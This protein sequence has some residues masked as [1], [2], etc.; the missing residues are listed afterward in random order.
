MWVHD[1]RDAD[2]TCGGKAVGL[3]KLLAAGLPVPGGFVIDGRAFTS[4]VGELDPERADI[5]HAPAQAAE[6]IATAEIPPELAAEVRDRAAELGSLVAVRSSAT[7]E[8]GAAGAAAGVFSSRRAVPIA[9][10]WDA[11]RAVWASALT[12]LTSALSFAATALC[13]SDA[14]GL[15]R[16]SSDICAFSSANASSVASVATSTCPAFTCAPGA[17]FT[18][19]MVPADFADKSTSSEAD[20]W[21]VPETLEDTVPRAAAAMT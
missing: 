20:T 6:R 11:I 7:I 17:T 8:D 10:V 14:F 1:L 4:I 18:A 12:P 21:P 9:E 2:A 16:R 15:V 3:A 13:W 5:G 19:V